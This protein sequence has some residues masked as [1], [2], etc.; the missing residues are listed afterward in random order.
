MNRTLCIIL[1]LILA[2]SAFTACA[3]TN[4]P[5]S[6]DTLTT[7]DSVVS[8]DTLPEIPQPSELDGDTASDLLFCEYEGYIMSDYFNSEENAYYFTLKLD[9]SEERVDFVYKYDEAS[10][11]AD[12]SDRIGYIERVHIISFLDP[13]ETYEII[14][15]QIIVEVPKDTC[16]YATIGDI[17]GNNLTVVGLEINDINHRSV[18]N[19]T[20]T[21]NTSMLWRGVKLTTDDLHIG[22]TIA[23]YYT[24]GILESFPGIIVETT[25]IK[26][27]DDAISTEDKDFD[28]SKYLEAEDTAG[29]MM[30]EEES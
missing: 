21:E 3:D 9:N 10:P 16:F 13:N 17:D 25:S 30:V 19:L 24:G 27:L 4:T 23:I 20:I 29:D 7:G 8:D 22:D 2:L 6:G 14:P 11:V 18:Y 15:A 28:L 26:L 5:A 1:S 12:M